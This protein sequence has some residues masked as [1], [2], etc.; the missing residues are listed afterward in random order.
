MDMKENA[1]KLFRELDEDS[2]K[3]FESYPIAHYLK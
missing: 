3:T 2:Q 1:K